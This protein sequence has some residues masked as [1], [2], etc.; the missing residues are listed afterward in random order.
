MI[1]H[2]WCLLRWV[3]LCVMYSLPYLWV[4][5]ECPFASETT[6]LEGDGLSLL[7][8]SNSQIR[9]W[10][11]V[12]SKGHCPFKSDCIYLH[13]L[14]LRLLPLGLLGPGVCSWPLGVKWTAGGDDCHGF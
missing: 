4:S 1:G 6:G 2:E 3:L 11:F 12:R 5:L 10:F 13:Q 8:S 14:R 7:L 9:C